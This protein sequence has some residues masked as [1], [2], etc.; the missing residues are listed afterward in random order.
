MSPPEPITTKCKSSTVVDRFNRTL[1]CN[2]GQ[3]IVP[4]VLIQPNL[5]CVPFMSFRCEKC[6]CFAVPWGWYRCQRGGGAYIVGWTIIGSCAI[7]RISSPS[8]DTHNPCYGTDAP[9]PAGYSVPGCKKF[10]RFLSY[11][12]PTPKNIICFDLRKIETSGEQ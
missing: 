6:G 7:A 3:S 4:D 2:K 8:G 12:Q 11:S 10:G 9:P 1:R 5:K